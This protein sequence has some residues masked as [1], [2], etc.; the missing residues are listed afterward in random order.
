MSDD[1]RINGIAHSWS[2]TKL[3]ID[4]E[5]YTRVTAISFKD[6]LEVAKQY[7]MARHHGPVARSR[8]RYNTDPVAITMAA[9]SAK[10]LREQLAAKSDTGTSY[11][12]PSFNMVLQYIEPDESP[13]TI[14]FEDCRLISDG[15]SHDEGPDALTTDVE[16]DPMFIRRNGLVLWD[17]RRL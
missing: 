1:I 10:A 16:I 14:D 12:T 3:K 2:S 11:G 17:D 4:G 15:A 5:A 6:S 13:V 9:G 7:G 8:G